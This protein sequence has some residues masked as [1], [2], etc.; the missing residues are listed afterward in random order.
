MPVEPDL[1]VNEGPGQDIRVPCE[2]VLAPSTPASKQAQ[3]DTAGISD[4][5][6]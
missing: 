1:K 2:R 5:V 6:P 3:A 4:G